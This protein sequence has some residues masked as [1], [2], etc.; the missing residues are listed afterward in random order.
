[1]AA[2]EQLARVL[3]PDWDR[4]SWVQLRPLVVAAR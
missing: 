1:M 2:E 4:M 3:G